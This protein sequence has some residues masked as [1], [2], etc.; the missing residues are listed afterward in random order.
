M[1][2]PGR[3][4][5]TL[6]VL[7]IVAWAQT[8]VATITS[9]GPFQLRGANVA[10]EQGVPSW[11]VMPGD[12]IQAGDKPLTVTFE[13][14]SQIVLAP[15]SS[16]KV[17]LQGKTP[18]FQLETGSARYSLK[19][20]DSVKLISLNNPVTPKEISG[21]LQVADPKNAGAPAGWWT[22]AHTTEV[23]VGSGAAAGL[24][25]GIVATRPV[26]P[27]KCKGNQQGNNNCQ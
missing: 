9:D 27:S 6:V 19:A 3:L 8:Q 10:P 4:V 2:R 11:P 25:I 15:G 7:A 26:S 14:G 24:A 23:L 20:L 16:A 21:I 22:T 17:D 12:T 13:D 5:A 18:V 1:H